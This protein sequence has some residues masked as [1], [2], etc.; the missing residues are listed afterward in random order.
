ML[1]VNLLKPAELFGA[2]RAK[3]D[4]AL[5]YRAN[6]ASF[7]VRQAID[8]VKQ[9][10]EH[11]A[12]AISLLLKLLFLLVSLCTHLLLMHR[13]IKFFEVDHLLTPFA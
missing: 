12:N 3:A 11:V 4:M 7:V 6:E 10:L 13:I 5:M 8:L 2:Q 1:Y 9:F